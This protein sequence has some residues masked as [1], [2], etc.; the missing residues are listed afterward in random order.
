MKSCDVKPDYKMNRFDIKVICYTVNNFDIV[1]EHLIKQ[2]VQFYTHGKRSERP[3]RVVLRGLP[4]V[5]S[6]AVKLRLKTD[7]QLDVLNVYAIKRKKESTVEET[8]Y[9][10]LFP[11]GHTNLKKL[12]AVKKVTQCKN[13]L[14]L[15]HGARNCY[16][17]GRYNKCGD[18]HKTEKC[19]DEK[20]QAKRVL[21][22]LFRTE[23]IWSR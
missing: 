9:I 11:K 6:E 7:F 15:G 2:K 4:E 17:Q 10:V 5:E 20:T 1:R 13:C 18:S 23:F 8:P 19:K 21:T 3:H 14:H 12:S 22:R 16:L